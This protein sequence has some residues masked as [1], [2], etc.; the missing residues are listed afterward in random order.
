MSRSKETNKVAQ[1]ITQVRD[2]SFFDQGGKGGKKQSY[3]SYI[4]NEEL[5]GLADGLDVR[6]IEE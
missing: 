2:D 6:E 3:L 4:Q 1:E 5:I